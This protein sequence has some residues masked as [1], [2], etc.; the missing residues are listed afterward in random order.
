MHMLNYVEKLIAVG[1]DDN[2]PLFV[3]GH[4]MGA[5]FVMRMLQAKEN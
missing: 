2:L 3:I 1:L 5:T 4:G